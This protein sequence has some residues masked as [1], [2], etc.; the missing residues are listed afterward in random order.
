MDG[1]M[2]GVSS[3]HASSAPSNL[4]GGAEAA[5]VDLVFVCAGEESRFEA[6]SVALRQAQVLTVGESPRFAEAGGIITFLREAD[7]VRFA[8]NLFHHREAKL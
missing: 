7:K 4:M 6:M 8:V 1:V 2:D 3:R 5:S